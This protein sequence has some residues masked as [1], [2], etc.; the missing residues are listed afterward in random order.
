MN[1]ALNQIAAAKS[2]NSHRR[3]SF[4]RAAVAGCVLGFAVASAAVAGPFDQERDGPRQEQGQRDARS[5]RQYYAPQRA[6]ERET[7]QFEQRQD[8]QRQNVQ[9]HYEQQ[10][11]YDQRQ[12]DNQRQFEQRQA[13]RAQEDQRR[14]QDQ[15]GGDSGRK[16]RLTPSER[17]DLRRQ[18]NEAGQDIYGKPPRR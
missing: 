7:R 6:P 11:Q 15:Q 9:R 16:G 8:V 3:F 14:A 18:I 12:V 1:I 4:V 10:R 2:A 13:D 5:E 17:A